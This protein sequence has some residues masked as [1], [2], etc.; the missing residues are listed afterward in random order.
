MYVVQA[1]TAG[2][3]ETIVANGQ[4]R[5]GSRSLAQLLGYP[6]VPTSEDMDSDL[7]D[8][9]LAHAEGAHRLLPSKQSKR[10]MGSLPPQITHSQVRLRQTLFQLLIQAGLHRSPSPP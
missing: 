5:K 4:S 3:V 2:G 10:F 6:F 7:N 9:L 1:D 8:M